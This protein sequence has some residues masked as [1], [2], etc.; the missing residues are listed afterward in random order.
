MRARVLTLLLII[1]LLVVA[2]LL[3]GG[4]SKPPTLPGRLPNV[5]LV[6]V[7]IMQEKYVNDPLLEHVTPTT[8]RLAREGTTC[9]LAYAHT[10]HTGTASR[11]LL[12]S[13]YMGQELATPATEMPPALQDIL[14]AKGYATG[15]FLSW[16]VYLVPFHRQRFAHGFSAFDCP[17]FERRDGDVTT[18]RAVD[19]MRSVNG[20]APWFAWVMYWDAHPWRDNP[21]DPE[22]Q[23]RRDD[24]FIARLLEA[25]RSMHAE[26][27]TI[28]VVTGIHG[29]ND[30]PVLYELSE[31]RLRVPLVFWAPGRVPAGRQIDTLVGHVDVVPT[32]LSLLGLPPLAS[33]QGSDLLAPLPADRPVFADT[34]FMQTVRQGRWKLVE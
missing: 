21:F 2:V 28:V 10:G 7:D 20:K 6:T 19:W 1:A 14:A 27:D 4:R 12:T 3:A 18:Q 8:R 17:S 32:L 29:H 11:S 23:L 9:V 25:L 24:D 26:N 13:R 31:K 33:A 5:L 34:A 16:C 22:G 30:P 15:A